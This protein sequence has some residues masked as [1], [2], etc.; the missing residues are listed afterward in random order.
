MNDNFAYCASSAQGEFISFLSSDDV[1][2]ADAIY[3]LIN[4]ISENDSAVFAFG[5]SYFSRN[6][7][8][9]HKEKLL[10]RPSGAGNSFYMD[11]AAAVRFFFPWKL[12]ST[13]MVGNLIRTCAYKNTGGFYACDLEVSGD[14]W[15]T[16]KLLS[17]GGFVY[18]DRPLA[19]FRSRAIGH[20][21]VD[22]DRR[23]GDFI[24]FVSVNDNPEMRDLKSLFRNCLVF[25][26]RSG[27]D[28]RTSNKIK[29]KAVK[30]FH[31]IEKRELEFL[32]RCSLKFPFV[33]HIFAKILAFPKFIRDIIMELRKNF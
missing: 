2:I 16:K 26:Y 14:V 15:I 24:D 22:P 20:R 7:P 4:V 23:I 31:R 29:I 27:I 32:A 11:G 18:V 5:N 10:V 8:K 19:L 28:K 30:I 25:I 33:F 6:I 17:Q 12:S 13:W 3:H 21:E 1:L 9:R